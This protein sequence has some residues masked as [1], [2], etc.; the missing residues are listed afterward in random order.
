MLVFIVTSENDIMVSVYAYEDISFINSSTSFEFL[1]QRLLTIIKA[2]LN[3][4][5]ALIL[6]LHSVII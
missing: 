2:Y 1:N 6:I 5:K 3:L 4:S